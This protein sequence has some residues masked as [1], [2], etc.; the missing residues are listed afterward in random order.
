MASFE[1]WATDVADVIEAKLGMKNVRTELYEDQAVWSTKAN[2][3][4]ARPDGNGKA[5]VIFDVGRGHVYDI[6]DGPDGAGAEIVGGCSASLDA[7]KEMRG[8]TWLI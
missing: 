3:G 6:A 1:S 8:S 5:T 2:R 4:V 7:V